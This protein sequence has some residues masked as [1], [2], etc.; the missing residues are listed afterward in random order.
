MPKFVMTFSP[1]SHLDRL[2]AFESPWEA[3]TI[4]SES[5][6]G[7]SS[8]ASLDSNKINSSSVNFLF[9]P[10]TSTSFAEG[11]GMNPS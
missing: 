11:F 8:P 9:L 3:L 4:N 6:S 10:W 7:P 5:F 2:S 1:H